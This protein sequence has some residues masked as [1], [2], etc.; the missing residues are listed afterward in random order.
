MP[1]APIA[2]KGWPGMSSASMAINQ[3]Y[4][5][6]NNIHRNKGRVMPNAPIATKG[7]RVMPNAP[8]AT[9]GWRVMPNAPIGTKG[10]GLLVWLQ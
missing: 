2:T 4:D 10:W 8:I 7:W 5:V 1:N 9:K 3:A 6:Q